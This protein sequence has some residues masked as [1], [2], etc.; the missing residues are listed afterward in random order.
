MTSEIVL[1]Y[2]LLLLVVRF[3]LKDENN[4]AFNLILFTYVTCQ[5][6]I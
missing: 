4:T 3:M 2:F 5:I 1:I 6:N